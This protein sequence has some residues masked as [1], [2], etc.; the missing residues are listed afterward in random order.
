MQDEYSQEELENMLKKYTGLPNLEKSNKPKKLIKKT[1]L[2][3][4]KMEEDSITNDEMIMSEKPDKMKSVPIIS[5]VN[6]IRRYG[7]SMPPEIT[8]LDF[9]VIGISKDEYLLIKVPHPKGGEISPGIKRK[10]LLMFKNANKI[11]VLDLDVSEMSM[12]SSGIRMIH[13]FNGGFIKCY[14]GKP[15]YLV[16]SMANN[17]LIPYYMIK[18]KN[19]NLLIYKE[20]ET[21]VLETIEDFVDR[22]KIKTLYSVILK[23]KNWKNFK[24]NGDVFN[25]FLDLQK[26]IKD[27]AHHIKIDNIMIGMLTGRYPA[28]QNIAT[29]VGYQITYS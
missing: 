5:L 23:E 12:Y 24:T 29:H 26:G 6:W 20:N 14:T 10:E 8:A 28:N 21:N 16:A 2:T 17:Q 27:N 11:P 4:V 25:Y 19:N 7:K 1:Q 15:N 3:S 9:R 22:E 13:P 18:I